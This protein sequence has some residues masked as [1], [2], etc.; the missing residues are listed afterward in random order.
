MDDLQNLSKSV[1]NFSRRYGQFLQRYERNKPSGEGVHLHCIPSVHPLNPS[2][3]A[4]VFQRQISEGVKC[5]FVA[6]G[7]GYGALI[8]AA[9]LNVFYIVVLAWAIYYLVASM[10]TELPWASCGNWW[11]TANCRSYYQACN[12]TSNDTLTVACD[13]VNFTSP[14][15]EYWEYVRAFFNP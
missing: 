12:E 11:N 4:C 10:A 8:A 3:Y 1:V 2:A 9:W 15:R 7:V 13:R 5:E 6:V 14:V